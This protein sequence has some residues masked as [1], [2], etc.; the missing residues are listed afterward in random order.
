VIPAR[1]RWGQHFLVRP[2]T[3]RR[4]ADASRVGPADTAFEVGPG[5]GALTRPLA[6]RAGRVLAI[7]IDPL[8]A[9]LLE[10]E[11]GEAG[12]VRILRG[13]VLK[14]T[15][16]GWLADA[17][18]SPPAILVSNLPYNV[19]TPILMRAIEEEGTFSRAVATIQREVARRFSAA[20]GSSDY[21]Y[22]SVRASAFAR[23]RVLFDLPPGAFRP[24]PRVTSSVLELV[25]R[26]PALDPTTRDRAIG[27][28][29]IAFRFRRKTL[30]NA[31]SSVADRAQV[32]GALEELGRGT[33]SR[34]EELSLTDYLALAAR[35]D[36]RP[37]AAAPR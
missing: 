1:K 13:D 6:E 11:L 8:R 22:L 19:A 18:F 33:K 5:E 37:V 28:A 12:N 31:L 27:L 7:E 24:P 36:A 14:N 34:A 30:V 4:I 3:A 25:P 15:F 29:S 10:R 21:G 32:G 17:G 20:P 2:E 16:A 23:A 35:L 9:D 26:T